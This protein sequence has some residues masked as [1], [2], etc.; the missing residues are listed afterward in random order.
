MNGGSRSRVTSMPLNRPAAMPTRRPRSRASGA[1]TPFWEAVWAISIDE[2]TIT[3]P[4]DRSMPAVRMMSVWAT[5]SVPTTATCWVIRE[6]FAG[7]RKRSFRMPNTITATTSTTAGLT[8][9]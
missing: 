5:A 3:A 4:T 7:A 2:S 1:G 9:G 8:A 6:R